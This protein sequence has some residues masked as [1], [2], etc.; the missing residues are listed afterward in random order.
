MIYTQNI[1]K[2]TLR[3]QGFTLIEIVTVVVILGAL[4]GL[5]LTKLDVLTDLDKLKICVG[6]KTPAGVFTEAVPAS[7]RIYGQAEPIY[8]T[9]DGWKE[10][11][12]G[13]R[14]LEELPP[15]ARRYVERIET[16]AGVKL[17]LISVG[18]G[19]EETIVLKNP[20]RDK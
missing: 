16:L 9:M 10:D 20:F 6:Y 17:F 18:P 13:A 11:I 15:N 1:M 7:L 19:R 14:H 12:S 8:E 5:A 2:K 3:L 4:T